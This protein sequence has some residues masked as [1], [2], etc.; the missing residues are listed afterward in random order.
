[1]RTRALVWIPF[2]IVSFSLAGPSV[3]SAQT[4]IITGAVAARAGGQPIA[5]AVVTVEGTNLS[6]VTSAVGRFQID[7]AP[8]STVVLNV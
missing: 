7:R 2:L 1:M 4:G 8:A 6:A 5:G 3:A